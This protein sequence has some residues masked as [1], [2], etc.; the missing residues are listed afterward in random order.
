MGKDNT[1]QCEVRP[2]KNTFYSEIIKPW[3]V[4]HVKTCWPMLRLHG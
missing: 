2:N 3:N 1:A 4:T